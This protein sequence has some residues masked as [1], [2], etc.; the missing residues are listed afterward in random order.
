MTNKHL[1]KINNFTL[2]FKSNRGKFIAL[3]EI[4]LGLDSGKTLALVGE[5]GCGKSITA[6]SVLGLL[7]ENAA[8]VEKGEIFFRGD[9]LLNYHK[10]DLRKIRGNRIAMI[11]QEPM[12]ALNPVYT[13]GDQVA[14]AYRIHKGFSRRKSLDLAVEMLDKVKIPDPGS[15]INEY[16]FQLSGGMRQ[17]VL[18]AIA[19]ACQPDLLIADEPTTALDVTIQAQILKLIGDLQ[20][21]MGT[22]VIF[23]THDLGLVAEMADSVAIMYAGRIIE[24]G[25]V[26]DIFDHPKHPYTQGLLTSIPKIDTP[27]G[28]KLA[29][30]KG[31]VPSIYNRHAGCMFYDRCPKGQNACFTRPKAPEPFSGKHEAACHFVDV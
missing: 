4:N 21:E 13:I 2:S 18:I 22:A 16:P 17:R 28:G 7:P 5:S 3:E 8:T 12:T 10:N 27:K 25:G 6:L 20:K 9:N 14:E 23:I 30:I 1:L 24:E 26:Y 11:F 29:T 15:R 31:I 19:L